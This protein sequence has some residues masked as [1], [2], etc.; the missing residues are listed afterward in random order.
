MLI[1]LLIIEVPIGKN[2]TRKFHL[3]IFIKFII[4]SY[5]DMRCR[6]NIIYL[7]AIRY[8]TKARDDHYLWTD[9]WFLGN[10]DGQLVSRDKHDL[11]S[12]TLFL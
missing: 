9:R 7:I 3:I 1:K 4:H 2:S 5:F 10:I 11:N 8:A 12:L 6:F